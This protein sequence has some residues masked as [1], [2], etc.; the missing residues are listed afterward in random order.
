MSKAIESS[1]V[2]SDSICVRDVVGFCERLLI[3]S[4]FSI[5]NAVGY[6]MVCNV[7]VTGTCLPCFIWPVFR[8]QFRRNLFPWL[9]VF[10]AGIMMIRP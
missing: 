4:I 3:Q 1:S 6:C 9:S 5:I 8:L 2:S 10:E 7:G